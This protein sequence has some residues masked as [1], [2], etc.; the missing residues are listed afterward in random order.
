MGVKVQV[1]AL[2]GIEESVELEKL[3]ILELSAE[4]IKELRCYLKC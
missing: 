2:K 4:C 3:K 1:E